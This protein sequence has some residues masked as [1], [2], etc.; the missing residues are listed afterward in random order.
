MYNGKTRKQMAKETRAAHGRHRRR[1][2][3]FAACIL[4]GFLLLAKT[5]AE[6]G[7]L[8]SVTPSTE[9]RQLHGLTPGKKYK[10]RTRA[11]TKKDKGQDAGEKEPVMEGT[12]TFTADSPDQEI[13]FIY[14]E[15][16]G[17]VRHRLLAD[18]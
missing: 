1:S 11:Y 2:I 3:L 13:L 17:E 6:I 10:I 18:N 4:I 15:L 12:Y 16:E 8:N 9:V 5:Q 7:R 14:D